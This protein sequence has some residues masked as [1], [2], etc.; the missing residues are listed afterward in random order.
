M[1]YASKLIR[2]IAYFYIIL[3]I[4][5][6]DGDTDVSYYANAFIDLKSSCFIK[7]GFVKLSEKYLYVADPRSIFKSLKNT[8]CCYKNLPFCIFAIYVPLKSVKRCF[9]YILSL[10]FVSG[11]VKHSITS[12]VLS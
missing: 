4:V 6:N 12:F 7:I 11:V 3:K 5:F 8:N 2:I 1:L 9:K 10:L